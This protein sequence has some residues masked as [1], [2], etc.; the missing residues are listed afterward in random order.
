MKPDPLKSRVK[1]KYT[2]FLNEDDLAKEELYQRNKE[3][4]KGG[5]K[6]FGI[7]DLVFSGLSKGGKGTK[8]TMHSRFS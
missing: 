1:K 5:Y 4:M 8:T 7:S 6:K 3:L 2:D